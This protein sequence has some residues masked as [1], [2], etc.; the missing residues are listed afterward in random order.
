M[1]SVNARTHLDAQKHCLAGLQFAPTDP[2]AIFTQISRRLLQTR[3]WGPFLGKDA[4]N[5]P[6]LHPMYL[7]ET[8]T[9]ESPH[10]HRGRNEP[11]ES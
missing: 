7:C 6:T 1:A 3:T 5:F 8:K 10:S 11:R 9:K 2:L 4:W